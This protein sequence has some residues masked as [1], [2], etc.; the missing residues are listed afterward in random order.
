MDPSRGCRWAEGGKVDEDKDR[1]ADDQSASAY[2]SLCGKPRNEIPCF[3]R[4]SPT[5]RS[6]LAGH[7]AYAEK[8]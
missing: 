4:V 5:P 3:A 7:D 1:H 8:A 2:G 6:L